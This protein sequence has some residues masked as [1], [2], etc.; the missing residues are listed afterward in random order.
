[1]HQLPKISY[2]K[3]SK[4]CTIWILK[5][6]TTSYSLDNCFCI[7]NSLLSLHMIL[8]NIYLIFIFII[9][10]YKT[11]IMVL[12]VIFIIINCSLDNCFYI[13]VSLLSLHIVYTNE[14]FI[15]IFIF[16]LYNTIKIIVSDAIPNYL[17]LYIHTS[18][19]FLKLLTQIHITPIGHRY[20]KAQ[21][22]SSTSISNSFPTSLSGYQLVYLKL[23]LIHI[24]MFNVSYHFSSLIIS[25]LISFTYS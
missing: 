25:N 12:P 10:L 6:C 1:M 7:I 8:I 18:H 5:I 9:M 13:I 4:P 19:S 17:T 11:L 22:L 2:P 24:N 16:I 23:I 14:Y 21:V 3:I 15:L 20:S